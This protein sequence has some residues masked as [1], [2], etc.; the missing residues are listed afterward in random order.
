MHN[1]S[2]YVGAD[3]GNCSYDSEGRPARDNTRK[4]NGIRLNERLDDESE[5]QPGITTHVRA[6][7]STNIHS[8]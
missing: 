5:R 2:R 3:Y 4:L 6:D 1:N 7:R 8:S